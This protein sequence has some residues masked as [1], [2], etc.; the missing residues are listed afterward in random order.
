MTLYSV[1]WAYTTDKL[2]YYN[3]K[4][5][6]KNPRF[7]SGDIVV[8]ENIPIKYCKKLMDKD[9]KIFTINPNKI[10]E[11]REGLGVE[12]TDKNDAKLIFQYY[13]KYSEAFK[14]YK[15]ESSLRNLFRT[16]KEIQKVRHSTS[17]RV[18]VADKD[19][20]N[21]KLLED[22]MKLEKDIKETM[23]KELE[24]HLIWKWLQNIK[25]I[26]V[27]SSAG[28][29][30]YIGDIGKFPNVSNLWSYFGLDV[31]SG[32]A[33]KR[34]KGIQSKYNQNARALTIGIIG[35]NFIRCKTEVYR[36]IFDKEKER[37]LSIEYPVGSLNKKYKQYKTTDRHISK[38]HA[39]NRAI[40]KMMKIFLSHYWVIDRQLNNYPT[41]PLYVHEKLKHETYIK[42]PRIPESL[43]PF[44]PIKE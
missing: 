24:N 2:I 18:Y 37:Q 13:E 14:P 43:L 38:L 12:K 42:P 3:G 41:R 39:Q 4:K 10:S 15:G 11:Y 26:D 22:L 27:T 23:R 30:S 31:I 25:G 17:M 6:F 8:G 7:E 21:E 34:Q 19:K 40:R 44:N 9:V 36:E 16:F 29:I 5:F 35:V 1:D 28:L 32:K 20:I 33:P